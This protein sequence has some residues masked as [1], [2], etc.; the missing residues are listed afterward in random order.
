MP[1]Q[2]DRDGSTP[3][4]VQLTEILRGKIEQGDWKPERRI[5]SENELHRTYGI[6]RMTARQVLAQL[7]NEGLLYRVQGKGTFVAPEKISTRSLAYKGIREQLEQ[8]GYA[9]AT[10]L[11]SI[12]V[13]EPDQ[14]VRRHLDL[15]GGA[16]AYAIRRLRFADDEPI[17]LHT[18]YI[19]ETVAPGLDEHDT[20]NQQLCVVLEDSFGLRM[21]HVTE[22]LETTFASKQE[23]E[24]LGVSRA[25]PLLL[26][27]Q[28][29]TNRA[30]TRFE[31]SKV[32]FRGDKIRLHFE[33]EL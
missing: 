15:P 25:A 9:T 4:Y 16:R 22:T 30:G 24:L 17:S 10:K 11:L 5:P 14:R 19:P 18:S 8:M 20:V 33:Y 28:Q 29:I 7:V 3:L 21:D 23:A 12:E 32:V 27:Q 26:L 31:Y 6:S 13:A 1:Q 2:L